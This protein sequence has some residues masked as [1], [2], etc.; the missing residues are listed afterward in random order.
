M[1]TDRAQKTLSIAGVFSGLKDIWVTITRYDYKK[2]PNSGCHFEAADG[3]P[4]YCD[5]STFRRRGQAGSE[6]LCKA[7]G[8]LQSRWRAYMIS[9]LHK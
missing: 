9:C 1:I 3:E 4:A 7:G 8:A 2:S 6:A 5:R